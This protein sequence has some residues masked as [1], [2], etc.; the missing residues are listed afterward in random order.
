MLGYA[1][2]HAWFGVRVHYLFDIC[3]EEFL[4]YGPYL[5]HLSFIEL[6]FSEGKIKY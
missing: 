1:F 4:P 6:T 2:S 5:N 3:R